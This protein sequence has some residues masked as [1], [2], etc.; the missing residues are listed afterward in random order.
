MRV[1]AAL[2]ILL[3]WPPAA[4]QAEDSRGAVPTRG[5]ALLRMQGCTACHSL[6]GSVSAG[7]TFY[8]RFGETTRVVVDGH[9]TTVMFDAA[10]IRASV[11][12]PSRMRAP[13]YAPGVM[14]HFTLT[15]EQ[16][17][18]ITEAIAYLGQPPA[19][20][21]R[22]WGRGLLAVA[23]LAWTAV[24]HIVLWKTGARRWLRSR[25]GAA[26]HG[27]LYGVLLLAS[28]L[29]AGWLWL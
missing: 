17:G 12:D 6:D 18:A 21:A 24:L 8:R 20:P 28:T 13:G 5:L 29:A 11:E 4:A 27:G 9:T 2:V 19:P 23:L 26:G 15:E 25:F 3:S 22:A 14:P 10:Y 1:F 7:P 16:L